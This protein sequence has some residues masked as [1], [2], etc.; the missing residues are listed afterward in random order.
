MSFLK[1]IFGSKSKKPEEEKSS[2]L[3]T[4]PKT[5]ESTVSK[6]VA[7]PAPICEIKEKTLRVEHLS[8][9]EGN[10]LQSDKLN[11]AF[12]EE[13]AEFKKSEF[14]DV[15]RPKE[16]NKNGGIDYHNKEIVSMLRGAAGDLIKQI[17]KKILSG[18]F[19]LT[20]VSFPIKVMVPYT[21]LQMIARSFFQIPYF[22]SFTK[23]ADVVERL[24]LTICA[25]V[26]PFFC[27]SF[28]LKPMNPVLGETY[29]CMYQDGSK[30]YV[31]QTSHHPPVSHFEMYGPNKSFYIAGYSKFGSSAG[32]N[33]LTVTNKGKRFIRF[34][35]GVQFNFGFFNV[36][37]IIKYRKHFQIL[38]G[39]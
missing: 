3:S 11:L 24:K 31:E 12:L 10:I 23:E 20:T 17:G 14:K 27:S 39:V 1:K 9:F 19:N 25:T 22:M 37:N 28:F 13:L 38:S 35:D 32:L 4:N 34:P 7:I 30:I 36:R 6:C 5:N 15:F 2:N 26:S 8:L 16:A 33:S 21:I 29:Q 18:D